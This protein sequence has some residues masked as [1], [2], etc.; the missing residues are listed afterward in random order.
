MK[1]ETYSRYRKCH[2]VGL[3]SKVISVTRRALKRGF[4]ELQQ[5][6]SERKSTKWTYVERPTDAQVNPFSPFPIRSKRLY[7]LFSARPLTLI[8]VSVQNFL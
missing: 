7:Q 2:Y 5:F 3:L 8:E 1:N 6:T 4:G